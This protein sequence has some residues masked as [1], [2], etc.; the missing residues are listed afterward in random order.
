MIYTTAAAQ[1][2]PSVEN[3]EPPYNNTPNLSTIDYA[4]PR[5]FGYKSDT[6]YFLTATATRFKST[7]LGYTN[8]IIG[9]LNV[10]ASASDTLLY[11][12]ISPKND[13]ALVIKTGAA[14][15]YKLVL[16]A[17][18]GTIKTYN[19]PTPLGQPEWSQ[20]A[21]WLVLPTA[22]G[23]FGWAANDILPKM[24]IFEQNIQAFAVNPIGTEIAYSKG[25]GTIFIKNL[26][27]TKSNR[28]LRTLPEGAPVRDIDWK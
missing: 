3:L 4:A 17:A 12:S 23:V 8:Y 20:S 21:N 16:Q 10:L 5:S 19:S 9:R 2:F 24:V 28:T 1:G 22:D 15:P 14:N 18:N 26:N 6:L 11:L 7:S 13:I 27:F 25:D